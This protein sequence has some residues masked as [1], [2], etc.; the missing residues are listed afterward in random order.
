MY[1]DARH[2]GAY[3]GVGVVDRASVDYPAI[4]IRVALVAH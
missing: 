1:I 4:G 2:V 3:G